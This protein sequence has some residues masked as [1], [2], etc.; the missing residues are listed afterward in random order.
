MG[1]TMKATLAMHLFKLFK[2]FIK[3]YLISFLLLGKTL[4]PSEWH[5][6]VDSKGAVVKLRAVSMKYKCQ[7]KSPKQKGTYMYVLLKLVLEFLNCLYFLK[8]SH[9]RN[10]TSLS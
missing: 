8:L 5:S 10:K 1:R 6:N 4:M 2:G 7:E 3:T 9:F